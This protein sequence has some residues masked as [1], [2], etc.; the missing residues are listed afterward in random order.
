MSGRRTGVAEFVSTILNNPGGTG[1]SP[2][3]PPNNPDVSALG[4]AASNH[5]NEP[6]KVY[7]QNTSNSANTDDHL[8]L[9]TNRNGDH[10]LMFRTDLNGARIA[11]LRKGPLASCQLE[12]NG[13]THVLN[14]RNY[15]S[16][17]SAETTAYGIWIPSIQEWGSKIVDYN[18]NPLQTHFNKTTGVFEMYVSGWI[19]FNR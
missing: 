9:T 13:S 4:A 1:G 16:S 11:S 19:N 10:C 2:Q 5:D 7:Y 12:L 18:G 3:L 14:L 15:T 6:I 17:N 8:I